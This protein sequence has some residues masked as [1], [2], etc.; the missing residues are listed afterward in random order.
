MLGRVFRMSAALLI[1]GGRDSAHLLSWWPW[2]TVL[3][4]I[5]VGIFVDY[6]QPARVREREAAHELCGTAGVPI[7]VSTINRLRRNAETDVFEGRNMALVSAAIPYALEYGCDT[8]LIGSC[9]DDFD[10]FP[11]CREPFITALS[12]ALGAYGLKLDAPLLHTPKSRIPRTT[13]AWSC[14]EATDEPCGVCLSC[15]VDRNGA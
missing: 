5:G 3:G 8:I 11:D 13:G 6:G 10:G 15:R 12:D 4:G 14:Y 2:H 9:R 7:V 1:S